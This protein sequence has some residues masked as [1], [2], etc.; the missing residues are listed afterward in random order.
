M[1]IQRYLHNNDR[2][3]GLIK[4]TMVVKLCAAISSTLGFVCFGEEKEHHFVLDIFI[5]IS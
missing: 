1:V 4:G 3:L 5:I 2:M